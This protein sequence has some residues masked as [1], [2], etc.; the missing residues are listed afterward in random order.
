[1]VILFFYYFGCCSWSIPFDIFCYYFMNGWQ[2]LSTI[3]PLNH[4]HIPIHPS[5]HPTIQHQWPFIITMTDNCNNYRPTIPCSFLIVSSC[6]FV[7]FCC[8][9]N[10]RIYSHKI[11]NVR[12]FY[13]WP[14]WK[15]FTCP[16]QTF[17]SSGVSSFIGHH[18]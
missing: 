4:P 16:I 9:F 11:A 6:C 2:H 5:I 7:F 13:A 10:N 14:Y 3:Q 8:A 17:E 18:K 1:M 12:L 15:V